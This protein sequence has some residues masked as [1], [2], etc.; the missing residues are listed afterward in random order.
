M[1]GQSLP[2]PVQFALNTGLTERIR[3]RERENVEGLTRAGFKINYRHDR[4]GI[5]RKYTTRGGGYY[6]NVGGS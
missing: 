6:I 3:E 2:I 1:Y 4:S 5:Y